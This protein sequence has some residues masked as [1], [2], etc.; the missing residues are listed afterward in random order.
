MKNVQV[1]DGAE[2]CT[3]SIYRLTDDEFRVIFP[4]HGQDIEF[5]EDVVAR[6][7]DD[8][9]KDILGPVWQRGEVDKNLVEGIHGTLFYQLLSKKRFYPT[10]KS[11]E[12]LSIFQTKK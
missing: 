11:N 6:L 12:M 7:G 3:Y 8:R 1:I 4:E 9:I 10:K 5:I 2:N